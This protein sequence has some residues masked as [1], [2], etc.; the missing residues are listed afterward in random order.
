MTKERVMFAT[1]P[2]NLDEQITVS[3]ASIPERVTGMLQ[4]IT[5]LLPHCD[6][7][8]LCLNNY[9]K[10]LS[11][12]LMI[13]KDPKLHIIYTRA[14]DNVGA[15]GK[16]YMAHR[17][18][19]YFLT[20]D[21]DIVYPDDYITTIIQGIERYKREAIVGFHGMY[22]L[23]PNGRRLITFEWPLERDMPIHIL[24]TGV[25]GYHS[26]TF[27]VQ[28]ANLLPGKIDEQI[29][30]MAQQQEIPMMLL[31]RTRGW[32]KDMSNISRSASALTC[33]IE[34]RKEA[35][36]RVRDFTWQ[37]YA[38]KEEYENLMPLT[39]NEETDNAVNCR[40]VQAIS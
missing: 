38:T 1:Q 21:D 14:V 34:A 9:D 39:Q 35:W 30:I 22:I 8:D 3:M 40:T 20:V 7:F 6:N 17:T 5:T 33:N 15:G 13:L 11:E 32:L 31:A 4:T 10:P 29:A 37:L 24:G 23:K 12:D 36:K 26:S 25:M 19:G 2:L 16:F 18:P 27:T 28:R